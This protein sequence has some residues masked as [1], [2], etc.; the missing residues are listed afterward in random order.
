MSPGAAGI[1]N[2]ALTGGQA[3]P[4]IPTL[5]SQDDNPNADIAYGAYERGYYLTA[6][7]EA[8]KRI[9]KDPNDAAA[10]TLLGELYSQG[11]GLKQDSKKAAEWYRLASQRGDGNAAFALGMMALRGEGVEKNSKIGLE[12]LDFAVGKG[13]P[14][15]SFNLGLLL[16]SQGDKTNEARAAALFERAADAQ[17]ADAQYALAVLYREG[18]GVP[19]DAGRAVELLEQAASNG[20]VAAEV[21]LAIMQFNGEGMPKDEAGAAKRFRI[22]AMRGNAIAQNRL[23]RIYAAGR[24]VKK[25]LIEAAAWHLAASAQG[26]TDSWLD[27]ALKG[28]TDDESGKAEALA[29]RLTSGLDGGKP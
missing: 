26:L 28:L 4:Q 5:P 27:E 19:K 1:P 21:E 15:A 29:K 9:E 22:A 17:I 10:M 18:R 14:A 20:N 12:L 2:Q 6:F 11:L 7:R 25:N 23:A 24:G 3:V 8:T 16:L 13:H